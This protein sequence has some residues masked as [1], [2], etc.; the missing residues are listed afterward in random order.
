MHANYFRPGGLSLDLPLNII[1]DI[2]SFIKFFADRL[3]EL[4]DLLS[5]NR[6]WKKRL[7]NVGVVSHQRALSMG[8]SGPM[9]R[10]SGI[11]WD[12]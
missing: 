12:L 6:I 1:S 9:L 8:F 10:G 4:E 3:D 7:T 2:Y 5:A 11:P